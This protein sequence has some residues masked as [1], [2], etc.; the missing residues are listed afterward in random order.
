MTPPPSQNAARPK[1]LHGFLGGLFLLLIWLPSF[2]GMFHFDHSPEMNEKRRPAVWPQ[3]T[4]GWSGLKSYLAGLEAYFNDHFGFRRQLI[5]WQ[6]EWQ[7]AFFNGGRS[8]VMMGKDGCLFFDERRMHLAENFQGILQFS[9]SELAQLRQVHEARRDWLAGRGIQ[10]IFLVA[11]DKQT[12]YPDLL[13]SWLKPT[14]RLT[15]F[16]QF[17]RYMREHSMVTVPDLRPALRSARQIAATYYKTDS[18]WNSFGG[19]IASEEIARLVA[20]KTGSAP[21]SLDSFDFVKTPLKRG[22]LS[23]LLGVY[24]QEDDLGLRPKACLPPLV[25][26][27]VHPEFVVPTCYT[28]NACARGVCVF[29][30]DSF[31]PALEPFLGYHFKTVGYFWAP[32]GFNT[33][34]IT[35]MHPDVVISEIVERHFD[36]GE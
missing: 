20:D 36:S 19:F 11:P 16:D 17:I 1:W 13:P 31:S 32:D 6:L 18:H 34:I 10:Y 26:T 15:K 29:F 5:H 33:N 12:I 4:P 8:D 35:R 25:K 2:D 3:F 21:L 9:P 22:D 23:I 7:L 27:V 24:A 14:G 30:G 28:S